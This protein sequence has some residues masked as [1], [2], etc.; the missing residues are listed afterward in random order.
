MI[1]G[2]T[3]ETWLIVLALYTSQDDDTK[4][5]CEKETGRKLGG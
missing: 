1:N 5:R 4:E 2:N 3:T